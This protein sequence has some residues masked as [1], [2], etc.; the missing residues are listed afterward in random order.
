MCM[1]DT[2]GD[3]QTN[4]VE[5]GDPC[6]V[7][8]KNGPAPFQGTS[9]THPGDNSK[10]DGTKCLPTACCNDEFKCVRHWHRRRR[11][12]PASLPAARR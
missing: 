10:F 9:V 4:G 11:G 6:C 2:D 3:G 1:A 8:A 5:L 12:A 7:W